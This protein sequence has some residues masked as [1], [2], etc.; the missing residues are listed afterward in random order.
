MNAQSDESNQENDLIDDDDPVT[1]DESDTEIE[2]NEDSGTQR[3][4][5]RP[6]W[7]K[8]YVFFRRM[9]NTKQTP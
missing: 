2:Q 3:V 4:R 1:E 5:K 6:F 7:A 9:V 8:D